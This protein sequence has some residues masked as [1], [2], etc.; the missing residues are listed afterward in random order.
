MTKFY[1]HFQRPDSLVEDF[2][3]TQC[4]SLAE[5]KAMAL[6]SVRELIADDVKNGASATLLAVK[7]IDEGGKQVAEIKAKD[8]LPETLR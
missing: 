4:Q 6:E 3:G 7:I 5:A 2:E 8:A 1:F